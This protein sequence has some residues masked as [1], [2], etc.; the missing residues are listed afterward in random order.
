L[1]VSAQNTNV[2]NNDG[3]VVP[4]RAGRRALFGELAKDPQSYFDSL[5]LFDVSQLVIDSAAAR[6]DLRI[7]EDSDDEVQQCLETRIDSLVGVDWRLEGGSEEVRLWL[8]EQLQRHY[9]TIVTNAFAAKLYGYSVQERIYA[10]RDGYIIVDRVSEKPFEWFVPRR[11]NTLW[12]R[13]KTFIVIPQTRDEFMV[14][15][16]QVD[17]EFKFLLTKH[18]AT[19]R[20]PRGVAIL[21]Y[22][23][24]PWFY[25][26][27]TWQFWMQFLERSGQPLLVGSGNDPAQIATQLALAVQD[28]VVAVPKDSKVEAIGGNSKGDAFNAAEDRLVRRIQKVLLGQTLTSDVGSGGKGARALG[29]VHNEVRQ[30]K[31][32]GDI[33]LVQPAVQNYI[34][35]L[36]ALNFPSS[37]RVVLVYSIDRG[38]ETARANRDVAFVNSGNLEFTE[39]YYE[40]EYGFRKGDIK[41]KEVAAAKQTP[42][43]SSNTNKNNADQGGDNTQKDGGK[44]NDQ[45]AAEAHTLAVVAA[46]GE[47]V[48][49]AI[50]SMPQPQI[51]VAP[52]EV[53]VQPPAI[54]QNIQMPVTLPTIKTTVTKK[55]TS[56][57]VGDGVLEATVTEET[58]NDAG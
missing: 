2:K 45:A 57:Q 21:A 53:T 33:K 23:F 34:D 19:W 14:D 18:R 47:A 8:T 3:K 40:R 38:L 12:F 15:G 58:H 30:D 27:A 24:W 28:A 37:R 46:V 25:R 39:Q 42:A 31:T 41:V 1:A 16:I 29:E 49:T 55:I 10:E 4:I 5:E 43:D 6:T 36:V 11:D 7:I 35:A 9:D 17:T 20:N 22:L 52:A 51:T 48:V 44:A 32:V 54:T 13:P 56:R 26:K 50:G